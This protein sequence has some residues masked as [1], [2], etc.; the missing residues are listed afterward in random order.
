MKF[1]N[2]KPTVD[3]RST[4]SA[5]AKISWGIL[6]IEFGHS[7]EIKLVMD[8]RDR[9]LNRDKFIEIERIIHSY[10]GEPVN[11]DVLN[12]LTD[13]LTPIVE[14]LQTIV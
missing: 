8:N 12:K 14:S 2:V 7:G 11:S 3:A 5:S 10:I 13:E 9:D 4:R 6:S 1:N